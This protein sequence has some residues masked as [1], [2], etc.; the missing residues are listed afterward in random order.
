MVTDVVNLFAFKEWS[1]LQLLMVLLTYGIKGLVYIDRI[2]SVRVLSRMWL[3]DEKSEIALFHLETV[4]QIRTRIYQIHKYCLALT[5]F[6]GLFKG[7]WQPTD[8]Y[9]SSCSNTLAL[10]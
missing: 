9:R 7:D 3:E 6:K 10:S 8:L 4:R 1:G 5:L 2:F